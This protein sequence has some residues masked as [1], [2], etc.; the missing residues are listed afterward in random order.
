MNVCALIPVYNSEHHIADVIGSVLQYTDKLIVVND[1]S[2]DGTLAI[3][4][5]MENIELVSYTINRG[6]GFALQQGFRKALSLGFTHTI[7]LDADGQHLASDIPALLE[8]TAAHPEALIV[9]SR[10][11]DNPNMPKGNVFANKFSNFWFMLQTGIRLPD[12]QTGLRVYPLHKMGKIHFFTKRYEAELEML[13]RCA[14]R[15]IQLLPQPI[16]IYYPPIEER[17]SHFRGGKDFVR[18]SML[19]TLL[20]VVALFYGYP[21]MLLRKVFNR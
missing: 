9:G 7:T 13:V 6:K 17:L 21:A 11:F 20:C 19:N 4:Q 8:V 10:R 16:H 15:N 1:G 5:A 12:T 3:L 2:T 14:W 18:I